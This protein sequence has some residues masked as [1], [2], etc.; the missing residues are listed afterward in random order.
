VTY[1]FN[2]SAPSNR[3]PAIKFGDFTVVK[4]SEEPITN[5]IVNE[6]EGNKRKRTAFKKA[7]VSKRVSQV[8]KP[9]LPGSV[10]DL[11]QLKSENLDSPIVKQVA[12]TLLRICKRDPRNSTGYLMI[13]LSDS[14][15]KIIQ[16][17]S[18]VVVDAPVSAKNSNILNDSEAEEYE[19]VDEIVKSE[20]LKMLQ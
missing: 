1:E 7:N 6:E 10:I 16:D 20:N 4:S 12:T 13:N 17:Y 19:W 15:M 3:V 5:F 14:S 11:T 8:L 2:P 9:P 18:T